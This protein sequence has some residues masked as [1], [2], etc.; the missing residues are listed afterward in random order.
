MGHPTRDESGQEL[1]IVDEVEQPA[2]GKQQW[3]LDG[4]PRN[5]HNLFSRMKFDPFHN[6]KIVAKIWLSWDLGIIT[7]MGY[8]H[9]IA[10]G[11]TPVMLRFGIKFQCC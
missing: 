1:Y 2:C 10:L 6:M 5:S 8:P 4:E 7:P 11:R 9:S 3:R